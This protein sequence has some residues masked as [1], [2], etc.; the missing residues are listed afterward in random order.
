V[1]KQFLTTRGSHAIRC[2]LKA[3]DGLLYPL[4]KSFIFINKPTIYI[5]YEDVEFC[6]FKRYDRASNS[7]KLLSIV[8]NDITYPILLPIS[9]R[10]QSAI[11]DI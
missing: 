5:K 11:N 10:L 1:P 2:S 3:N 9:L 6:E 4:A 7:G 8:K